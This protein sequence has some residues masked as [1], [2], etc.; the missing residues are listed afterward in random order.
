[1]R[2]V[3]GVGVVWVARGAG[4]RGDPSAFSVPYVSVFKQWVEQ[5][6]SSTISRVQSNTSVW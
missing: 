2:I 3:L 1:M 6:E 5:W 4:V